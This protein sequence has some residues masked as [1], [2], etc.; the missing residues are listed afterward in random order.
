ML[1][2]RWVTPTSLA[3][4]IPAMRASFYLVIASLKVEAQGVFQRKIVGP[5]KEDPDAASLK[6]R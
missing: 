5:F 3:N 4:F 2:V 6:V 1:A